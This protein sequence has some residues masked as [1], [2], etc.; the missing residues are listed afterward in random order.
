M[1]SIV[2]SDKFDVAAAQRAAVADWDHL[3]PV[4]TPL[5]AWVQDANW[6]VAAVLAPALASV[7]APLA[8]FIDRILVGND[9]TWKYHLLEAVVARSPA[10]I[11]LLRPVLERIAFDP[12]PS[13][14]AEEVD[15][16]A[17]SLLA[18]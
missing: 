3:R 1:T 15:Q 16:V 10:L 9:E 12:T 2:P 11:H 17:R 5:L 7:G 4:A 14:S 13:E 6:P 18:Q 8:P